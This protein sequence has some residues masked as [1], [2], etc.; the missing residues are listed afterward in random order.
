YGALR[1]LWHGWVTRFFAEPSFFF[2]YWG[3]HWVEPLPP[4][5]MHGAFVVLAAL[6]VLIAIGLWYRIAIVGFALLF[7]YVELIDVTN[8]LNHYYLV[9]LL[10]WLMAWMPLHRT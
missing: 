9:S 2:K 7:T 10:A 3:F 8:Y 6:G 4:P 5:A 1:F